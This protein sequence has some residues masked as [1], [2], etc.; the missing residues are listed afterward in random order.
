MIEM[1]EE[2]MID[3]WRVYNRYRAVLKCPRD[4]NGGQIMFT[5]FRANAPVRLQEFDSEA[6]KP[7]LQSIIYTPGSISP[8][9]DERKGSP[10]RVRSSIVTDKHRD[11]FRETRG[12]EYLPREVAARFATSG[13]ASSNSGVSRPGTR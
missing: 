13:V 12:S 5:F 10:L 4:N 9:L 8:T 3:V 11:Q 1:T 7:R 2:T 6:D